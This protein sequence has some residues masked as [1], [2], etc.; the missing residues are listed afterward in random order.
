MATFGSVGFNATLP[1][2][3]PSLVEKDRLTFWTDLPDKICMISDYK[4]TKN[5]KNMYD[6]MEKEFVLWLSNEDAIVVD[7]TI[8]KY[9]KLAQIQ[10]G[11]VYDDRHKVHK[12]VE[13]DKNLGLKLLREIMNDEIIGK[14]VVSY[15]HKLVYG[16]LLGCFGETRCE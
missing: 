5:M 8:T 6:A 12:L 11:W 15:R 1:A 3:L 14:V 2:Y 10:C 16:Q 4:M 13:D 9:A 7:T